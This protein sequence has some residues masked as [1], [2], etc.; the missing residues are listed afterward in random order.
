LV[1]ARDVARL[2]PERLFDCHESGCD[3]FL[4]AA[5]VCGNGAAILFSMKH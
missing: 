2:T 4:A 1:D 3:K 5:H